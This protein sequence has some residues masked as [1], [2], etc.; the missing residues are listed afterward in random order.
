MLGYLNNPKATAEMIDN[1]GWLHTGDI[2]YLDDQNHLFISDRLKELIKY[3]G[4]QV[5]PA[6]LE[7]VLC[8]HPAVAD[9]GVIGIPDPDGGEVPRAYVSLKQGSDVSPRELQRFVNDRVVAYKRLRGGVEVISEIPRSAAG[10]ILR[11]QLKEIAKAPNVDT[12]T[13]SPLMME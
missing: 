8:T 1:E 6:E 3:K 7:A 12:S 4:L 5:P 9:A 2:G 11:K 13:F 10:K